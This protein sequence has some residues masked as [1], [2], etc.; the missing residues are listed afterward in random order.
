MLNKPNR[1]K[2]DKQEMNRPI[3][4]EQLIEKYSLDTIWDYIEEIVDYINKK[5]G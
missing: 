3:N 5:E 2:V 1:K 4:I